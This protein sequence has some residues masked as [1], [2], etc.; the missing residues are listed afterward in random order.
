LEI[1]NVRAAVC[2][3][4]TIIGAIQVH[5][6]EVRLDPIPLQISDSIVDATASDRQAIGA[7]G[8]TFA[9]VLLTIR[10]CTVFGIVDVHAIPLGENSIFSGCV[11]VARRQ[12]GCLRFSSVSAKCRTPRRYRC[13][14]DDVI[15]AVKA[16]IID[17]PAKRASE[18]A[19]ETLR[20]QPRF[21]AQRYGSP[22]YAQLTLECATEIA[23]GADDESEMGAFHDL[24]QPQREANLRARL[25][26]Y[27][28]AGIDVGI[29]FAN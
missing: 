28:P 6:D 20:V 11:N 2:I 10:R 27:T 19:N 18:I 8:S 23:R 21:V 15:A 16:K 12:I 25:T 22:T 24:F 29:I 3:D 9:H 1:T 7:S 14:P 17:D 26:E 13:Q 5:E 4:H